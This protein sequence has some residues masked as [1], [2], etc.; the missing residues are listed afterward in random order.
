[1]NKKEK[2]KFVSELTEKEISKLEYERKLKDDRNADNPESDSFKLAALSDQD[3]IGFLKQISSS[4]RLVYT[5][6]MNKGKMD[7]N[8]R[9]I[10]SGITEQKFG[11]GV[12][13]GET[14]T[15]EDLKADNI[16]NFDVVYEGVESLRQ[17]LTNLS[18]G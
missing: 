18:P 2:Q 8:N 4:E 12:F 5:V 9:D 17:V 13:Q 15:V 11:V 6:L 16:I 10:I 7:K 1:M 14:K 3:Y